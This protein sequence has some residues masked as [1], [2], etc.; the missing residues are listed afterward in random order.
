MPAFGWQRSSLS[1]AHYIGSVGYCS[2]CILMYTNYFAGFGALAAALTLAALW[3]TCV[4]R[5]LPVLLL[6]IVA[7]AGAVG[8][9][10]LASGIPISRDPSVQN[11]Y[12]LFPEPMLHQFRPTSEVVEITKKSAPAGTY[13]VPAGF[14]KTA[15]LSL[16]A[17]RTK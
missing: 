16:D 11:P 2:T 15:T 12:K 8:L 5:S 7:C 17:F 14:T 10:A 3:R 1:S 13:A 6:T 4:A 9:N